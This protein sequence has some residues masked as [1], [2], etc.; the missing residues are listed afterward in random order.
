MELL[1]PTVS[2]LVSAAVPHSSMVVRMHVGN[3]VGEAL[4]YALGKSTLLASW[5]PAIWRGYQLIISQHAPG[6]RRANPL[7]EQMQEYIITRHS[8]RLSTV[9][10]MPKKGELTL[11]PQ[12]GLNV[13]DTFQGQPVR[14][15]LVR[16]ATSNSSTLDAE[17]E[18]I[19]VS[20]RRLRVDQLKEFVQHLCKLDR[21][22]HATVTVYRPL[23]STRKRDDPNTVEWD[24]LFMKTNKT[25]EN[26]IYSATVMQQLFDDVQWFMDN[27]QWYQTRGLSYKRGYVLHGPPGTGK[28]SVA[29]ILAHR[30]HLPI[31]VLDLSILHNN[32]DFTKLVTEI[33]YLADQRYIISIEDLDRTAMFAD[34]Y[35]GDSEKNVT[36]QCFLNFLDGVVETHGRLCIFS[37]NDVA[38]LDRHPS[39]AALFRPGRIDRRVEIT[40]CDREQLSKLFALYYGETLEPDTLENPTPLSP[41]Q[42]INLMTKCSQ[43]EVQAYLQSAT[44][45]QGLSPD[46]DVLLSSLVEEAPQGRGRRNNRRQSRR[47]AQTPLAR[48][49]RKTRELKRLETVLEKSLKRSNQ[50]RESMQDQMTQIAAV[51]PTPPPPK[52][53]PQ[54]RRKV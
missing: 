29:K 22:L 38:V 32:S 2:T 33:N 47:P 14:I 53:T 50:L 51:T 20:S 36:L 7:F 54:K 31:F 52:A 11:F 42:V 16:P 45:P 3:M 41:A 37:A 8:S 43:A 19:V 26:T 6:E 17:A 24:K 15:T 21:S 10:L 48:A 49:Q 12:T 25:L 5:M 27:E 39:S 18:Q 40:H 13:A 46:T 9:Q 30:Y 35:Y 23:F 44:T 28:T 4:R 1:V 34:R